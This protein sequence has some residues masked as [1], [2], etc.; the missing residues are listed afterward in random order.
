VPAEAVVISRLNRRVNAIWFHRRGDS[1]SAPNAKTIQSQ[2]M[3]ISF[4]HNKQEKDGSPH[5]YK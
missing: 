5:F 3:P 1:R 4:F 2:T